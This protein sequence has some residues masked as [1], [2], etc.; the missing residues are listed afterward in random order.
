MDDKRIADLTAAEARKLIT[1]AVANGVLLAGLVLL[2][3]HAVIGFILG[4]TSSSP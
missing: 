2:L 4:M 3:L 1:S